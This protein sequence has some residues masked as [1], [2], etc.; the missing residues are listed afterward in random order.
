M[1]ECEEFPSER[2]GTRPSFLTSPT[3]TQ[4]H[5]ILFQPVAKSEKEQ[6][7]SI[8]LNEV[9]QSNFVFVG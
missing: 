3:P 4:A 9:L 6:E 5:Y 1:N 8:T 2:I 7:H